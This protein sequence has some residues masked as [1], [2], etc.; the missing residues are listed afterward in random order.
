MQGL[1]IK[2]K[3]E[4]ENDTK[5]VLEKIWKNGKMKEKQN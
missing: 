5:M 3:E 2:T 1:S 4:K